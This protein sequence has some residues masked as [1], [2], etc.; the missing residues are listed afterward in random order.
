[1]NRTSVYLAAACLALFSTPAFAGS[2]EEDFKNPP[3]AVRPYVWWHWMGPNFTKEGITKD[4]EAMKASGIGGATIFN[5]A[6]GVQA[7]HS[8]IGNNPWPQQTYR[9]PAYWEAIRH[10]AAEAER[11]GLE[12]GLH[13]TVG[14]STT[15]G[16]WIDEAKN[17]QKVVWRGVDVEGGKPVSIDLPRPEPTKYTGFGNSGKIFTFYKDI[18]VLAIPAGENVALDQVLDLTSQF[19][20]NRLEWNA[21]AGNWRVL[22]IGHAPTGANPHPLPDDQIGK[23]LEADKMSQEITRFHWDQ[24]IEPL[25]QNLGASLGKGLRHFLIDS[26]EAGYQNW[27]PKFREEFLKRKGYDPVP[28][29]ATLGQPIAGKD[30]KERRVIGNNDMTARFEADYR[31][32]IETLYFENGWLPALEKMHAVGCTL[33]F[34]AY[35]GPFNTVAGSAIAD[36]PMHEFWTGG[37]GR[38]DPRVVAAGRAAGRTVIGAEAFTGS[39]NFSQW[40]ETPAF[41]KASGDG[42]YA[43]GVNRLVLHTWVHQPFDDRYK[44]AAGMGWWGTHFNRHQTWFEPGKAY[45]QY[46]G[47]I[48]ALLQRGETPADFLSVGSPQGTGDVIAPH[49]LREGRVD[50]RDGMI[51]L[52]SGRTYRFLNFQ[53]NGALLPLDVQRIGELLQKGGVVVARRPDRSPSLSGYPEC[54]QTVR[55]L[56]GPIW[57]SG[58][59][60]VRKV[61]KGTLFTTGDVNAALKELK[62]D[63]FW[64]VTTP[65]ATGI[66]VAH[67]RDAGTDLFFVSNSE[68]KKQEITVSFRVDKRRPELWDAETGAITLAPVW[69]EVAGRTEVDLQLGDT[70]S[71]FVVFR[72]APMPADH[73]VS[74]APQGA[75]TPQSWSMTGTPNGGVNLV[76]SDPMSVEVTFASG[77]RK[78]VQLNAPEAAHPLDGPWDVTLQ[79]PVQAPWKITLPALIS[80]DQHTDEPVKYFSGT[81]TYSTTFKLTEQELAGLKNPVMLDLGKVSDLARVKVNGKDLGVIWIAPF[82]FEITSALRPGDNRIEIAA[83]NT[84]HNRLVGDEQYP[85]DFE[86]GKES[87]RGRAIKAFP[88][89]FIKNQP[90]PQQGRKCFVLWY[91]HR[92][93]TQ[94]LP[95]GL[96]GPVSVSPQTQ[97]VVNPSKQ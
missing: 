95:A 28:W 93:D 21:P 56:A 7:T 58:N 6:S 13:N 40:T 52:P 60:P 76:A 26:Y 63:P 84:W 41:L 15:G 77:L 50:V 43:S 97:I 12:L 16:P 69:R 3:I 83:T 67:R 24:V 89:W 10:A 53:N 68:A 33:Q 73:A 88:D 4:L 42:T 25:K 32:M 46:L 57:G 54:D 14:Y 61:G 92:K 17:M 35:G 9:S 5:I 86:W 11:L 81:A 62:L 80:L 96:I 51:V 65:N 31:E 27:T 47:R 70:K 23:A 90:R 34:E 48:Q 87:G 19:K 1:M 71:I 39:P 30:S 2:L 22:R 20:N 85:A 94:L 8:P 44:P 79:S 37:T 45:F 55:T 82:R 66:R 75:A 18:A 59:E 91:Y 78:T 74:V 29:L 36:L 72:D 38:A 64:N 49:L